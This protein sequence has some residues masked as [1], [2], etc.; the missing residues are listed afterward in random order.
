MALMASNQHKKASV[1]KGI[2]GNETD[3]LNVCKFN[4]ALWVR[5][6]PLSMFLLQPSHCTLSFRQFKSCSVTIEYIICSEHP[7]FGHFRDVSFKLSMTKDG[8]YI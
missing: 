2:F 3:N 7:L 1:E 4:Q 8:S 6:F 5:Y